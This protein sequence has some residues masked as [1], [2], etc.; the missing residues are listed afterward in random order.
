[1]QMPDPEN[2]KPVDPAKG[3]DFQ[4]FAKQYFKQHPKPRVKRGAI[5]NYSRKNSYYFNPIW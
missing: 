1:M 5:S 3:S 4:L 2:K